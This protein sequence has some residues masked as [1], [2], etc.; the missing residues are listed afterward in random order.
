MQQKNSKN[1]TLNRKITVSSSIPE[2]TNIGEKVGD[3]LKSSLKK[4]EI[5]NEDNVSENSSNKSIKNN[6]DI[7]ASLSNEDNESQNL[8]IQKPQSSFSSKFKI[9]TNKNIYGE[10]K[11]QVKHAEKIILPK[12][13]V[14]PYSF[15]LKFSINGIN[16][17]NNSKEIIS[18]DLNEINFNWA[19]RCLLKKKNFK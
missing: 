16:K 5:N 14:P 18:D 12:S 8:I 3:F 4:N 6:K 9:N 7:Q 10:L 11:V 15:S 17:V 2:I 1:K 13:I 19:T